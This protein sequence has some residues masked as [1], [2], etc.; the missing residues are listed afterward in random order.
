MY[1]QCTYIC[2]YINLYVCVLI[3]LA[4]FYSL[5]DWQVLGIVVVCVAHI[6]HSIQWSLIIRYSS[7]ILTIHVNM[8]MYVYIYWMLEELIG[9]EQEN[10]KKWRVFHLSISLSHRLTLFSRFLCGIIL[11]LFLFLYAFVAFL[12]LQAN[13]KLFG[14]IINIKRN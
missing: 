1:V 4:H 7:S 10:N 13:H 2:T 12:F 8:N 3:Y 14:S 11:F 5:F 9:Q 6:D